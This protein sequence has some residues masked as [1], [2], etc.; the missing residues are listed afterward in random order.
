MKKVYETDL[1]V[2]G[3]GAA[4]LCAAA[5]AGGAG[6]KVTVIESDL[7]AGGQ[8]VKQ[9]HKF[10]G[11][12]DEYAGTRGYKIADILLEEIAGLGDR[13]QISCNSTVTGYYPEDGVY[14]VM[15]GE[16][17]YYR[18]KAKKAV[19]ATG[20]QERMI[21]FT[22]N[23]LPGVYGAGAVQTL[24]NVYGV[25]PGKRVVMVGAGNIGLIVSYQLKQAGVEVAAVVEAM[26]KIGGYWVHAAKIR[27]LGIP[28]LLRHTVVEAIGDKILEGAV[29]Q[30]L[31]DKFQ[32]IGEPEKIECDII[33]MAVG[34]T[35]TT[36]LFW[37]AGCKMQYVPQ[38]CG[39]VPYRD[40]NMR[41]S[42]PDIWVAGD[43]SGIEEASAAMV[44]GR[45]AGHSAAK[46]L[47][48]PVD[49]GKFDEYWTRLHHLRAGEV[50][51]KITAG[52]NQVLVQ[53]WEA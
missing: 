12:K 40:K 10:F 33:C 53:G 23:D 5:E 31:D 9:T 8:L 13:V 3:G 41:T 21:P 25:V 22:N 26:P 49:D 28:V 30:E 7:H 17:E 51:E 52:I 1:L 20:A 15:Q 29:I 35:P 48:L 4:G 37:Q 42:N 45:V 46:A 18:I 2:I 16:E 36:E 47:G 11:S 39:Y 32:L 19:I 44:E 24:M 6:A 38:L 34:L 27:R 50:G 14:T 43:A